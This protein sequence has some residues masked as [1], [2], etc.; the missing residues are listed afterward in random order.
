MKDAVLALED[1]TVFEGKGIGVEGVS[2]GELVFATPYTGYE[3]ALTDPS[4]K[5]QVLMFTY[6]LIGNYGISYKNMQSDSMKADGLVVREACLNPSHRNA[7]SDID[8]FLK[9]NDACGISGIDTRL[10]TTRTRKEGTVKSA[11]MVGE[12]D[13]EKALEE[14]K[15]LPEITER[16]LV[17]KV[18]PNS[19][20]RI[21][22]D[23]PKM[24]ILDTGM[25]KNILN[26]LKKREFDIKVFPS[27]TG[28]KEIEKFEPDTLFVSNGPGDPRRARSAINVVKHFVDELPIFGICFGIQ[29]IALALG[30][31][32]YKMKFGHR[33]GNQPVKDHETGVVHIT[34]QNHGFAVDESSLSGTGLEVTQ[35][36][37]NDDT[38]EAIRHRKKPIE[39]V[40]YHPEACP[41]PR[42]TEELFFDRVRKIAGG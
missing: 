5:G 21:K 25:K 16:D 14:A 34:S 20:Y 11:I 15:N 22:N 13:K 29:I 4:Y 28:I 37:P 18:S 1:G 27:D 41:G 42:D 31:Q 10:L 2:K 12:A 7:E 8:E 9:E 6:P 40:Q 32:T 24:A 36:N 38:V 30:G 17:E 33:G 35:T 23:G 26:N 39:A 19:P 3:E